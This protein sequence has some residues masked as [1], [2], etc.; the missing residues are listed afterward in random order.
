MTEE[1]KKNNEETAN[2]ES[3]KE[4]QKNVFEEFGE[5]V[6]KFA[7]KTMESIKKTIDRAMDSRNT[8]LSI[9][10]NEEAN[11]KLGMLVEAG[12]FK[13]RSESAAFLIE[14]G[15]KKQESLFRRI[16]ERLEQINKLKDELKNIVSDEMGETGPDDSAKKEKK[17]S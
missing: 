11:E 1:S 16:T 17:N 14:E 4:Q 13:S 9:R 7:S 8:V 10:V 12:I 6:E 3:Q 15:I 2:K 5:Q